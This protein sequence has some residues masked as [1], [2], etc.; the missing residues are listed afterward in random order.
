VHYKAQ[1]VVVT[2]S[3]HTD[4]MRGLLATGEG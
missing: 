1:P 2:I 3:Y 4:L